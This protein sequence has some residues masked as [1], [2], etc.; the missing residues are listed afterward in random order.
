[1]N[2]FN[3]ANGWADG[4][5][6]LAAGG[7]NG[8][9]PEQRH[10][11][12][13][14]GN[15]GDAVVLADA[16]NW[17]NAGT[18]SN[19]GRIYTV[20]GND[21]VIDFYGQGRIT[22]RDQFLAAPIVEILA[23]AYETAQYTFSNSLT[24]S[25]GN[26]VLIGT[27]FGDAINGGGGE[28]LIFG[29]EGNDTISGGDGEDEILG[30]SGDDFMYGGAGDDA[31]DG[32]GGQSV[33]DGG[34]GDDDGVEYSLESG[35]VTI[36]LSGV[37]QNVSGYL[38]ADGRVL[39]ADGVT[40]DTLTSIEDV[41]GT[42]FADVFYGGSG[43]RSFKGLEGNDTIV[44]GTDPDSWVSVE[45]WEGPLGVIVNLSNASITVGGIT[46]ASKTER[47]SHGD[48]DTFA[49]S[50]GGFR[51]GGSEHDDYLRGR[52]DAGTWIDWLRG[53][54]HPRRVAS[55]SIRCEYDADPEDGA[56]YG[57]IVN[58]SASSITVGGVTGYAGKRDRRCQSGARLLR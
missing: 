35:G 17:N 20:S 56:I 31:I 33:I 22:V 29:N 30:G 25:P 44:G 16:A 53:Q 46:V 9:N 41:H 42:R 21:L 45:N 27:S 48:T 3:N 57:A 32:Q 52:D 55:T 4:S 51:I 5:Y 50:A 14:T 7:A 2:H 23:L 24:G 54:R 19:G 10:Q 15:T 37:T 38:L 11:L 1:M 12:V 13:V 40:E 26:D 8:A 18:V 49:L 36:N 43:Y 28:D 34:D 58:L 47:D 39:H 6:N